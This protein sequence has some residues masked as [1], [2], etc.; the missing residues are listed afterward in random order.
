MVSWAFAS[1]GWGLSGVRDGAL[2]DF[3]TFCTRLIYCSMR[4]S[5][6]APSTTDELSLISLP[7]RWPEPFK[8]SS[9]L[10]Q[11][12]QKQLKATRV[13]LVH[14]PGADAA[15]I[16]AALGDSDLNGFERALKLRDAV[17]WSIVCGFAL[18]QVEAM[19]AFVAEERCWNAKP[20][21][22]WVDSWQGA[23]SAT[24]LCASALVRPPE[25][26]SKP[27]RNKPPT[28]A[29]VR[30]PIAL[31][32]RVGFDDG[33]GAQ[34][35]RILAIYGMCIEYGYKYVHTP[36]RDIEY[37]GL[38]S[39][40]EQKNSK[41]FV[42]ECNAFVARLLDVE[43]EEESSQAEGH[44]SRYEPI[45]ADL[46]LEQLT[47]LQARYHAVYTSSRGKAKA[48]IVRYA[49]PYCVSDEH[50]KVY[51]HVRGLYEKRIPLKV[52]QT[53]GGGKGGGERR[54]QQQ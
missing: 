43:E 28:A 23:A 33:F 6:S 13:R 34:L 18:S 14:K 21:G 25:A 15:A 11:F 47:E 24:V 10:Q 12:L 4:R 37:Q 9:E 8:S 48:P 36:L 38:N 49:F 41:E 32:R 5:P 50:P 17:G 1:R 40:L 27:R 19:D 3:S 7:T 16:A 31:T 42:T 44:S 30:P 20:S 45:D 35:Q 2:K 22:V 52:E 54:R 39:L 53:S 51:R 46:S 26:P 29:E